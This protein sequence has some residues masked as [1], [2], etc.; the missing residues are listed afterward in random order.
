MSI[1]HKALASLV[2]D[3]DQLPSA[4]AVALEETSD[5]GDPSYIFTG[6]IITMDEAQPQ[7]E[8]I[9]IKGSKIVAIGSTAEVIALAG[10]DTK[11]I[12]LGDKVM[13]P[14]LIE[15][16]M[17]LWVTAINYDWID[18]SPF[19]N[20]TVADVKVRITKAAKAAKPGEWVLGKLFDPSLLPDMPDLTVSDLDPIAP[21]NPVFIF[22]ASMHFAYVNSKALELAGIMADTKDP[23]GGAYGRN[24]QGKL[25]GVLS[26]MSAIQPFLGHVDSI[27]PEVVAKNVGRITDDAARVGVTT[28][29]EAA[30]G[31]LFGPKEIGLLHHL[32]QQGAVKTRVSLALVDEIAQTWPES[33]ETANGA[34]NQQ[35]WI[36][37]R[38]IV[39]DGS[40]QGESGYQSVPYLHSDQTGT[41]DIT[42]KTL[43][44]RLAWCNDHGWQVMVHAN[45]DAAVQTVVEAFAKA[46]KED[47]GLRHRIEHCSLVNDDTQF[48]RMRELGVSPSFLI[49]HVYYWGKTLRD[50]VLGRERTVLLDRTASAVAA[51]LKF[52][53]HSDY[54]VSPINPLHY[55]KVATTRTLWD[56]GEVLGEDQKVSVQ[57]ALKAITIDAAWQINADDRL[58]SL[59]P[60]KLADFVLLDKDPQAV[61]PETIDSIKVIGTWC[62][63]QQ[64]FRA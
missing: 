34:G 19:T 52:T 59:T 20:K 46:T 63:G 44:E 51:G 41:L 1:P 23:A 4:P 15:S 55:V 3:H 39:T 47:A 64:V 56:G 9:A 32:Q 8:A 27:T 30:T 21:D 36:G 29:R 5:A 48:D 6:Q 53:M 7:A 24:A 31:A 26:E 61:E 33:A 49:N 35:V 18:C 14:G 57:Q 38:K 16:H 40:N 43:E 50:N 42:P 54:N 11:T 37:A 2:S 17:H 13:Y 25:N 22:N 60:G 10:S 28:M 58:G 62:N 45:G 12:E